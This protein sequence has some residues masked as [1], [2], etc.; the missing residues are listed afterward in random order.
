MP[1]KY[2]IM[3]PFKFLPMECKHEIISM[4][5]LLE[6]GLRL[7]GEYLDFTGGTGYIEGDEGK[8]FPESY[9]WIQ[10]NDF[11]KKYS[12][13][14]SIATI[15]LGPLNFKGCICNINYLGN[16]YRMATYLGVK[17]NQCSEQNVILTQRKY[18][19]IID[20]SKSNGKN[21]SAPHAGNMVRTIKEDISCKANFKFFINNDLL[22][23][24]TD[25]NTS[26]EYAQ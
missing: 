7:N 18:K 21:L 22:F 4:N 8:S 3:G 16:E 12:I 1:I 13:V 6:G 20:V 10:C 9:T 23:D 24:I 5:H 2:D 17:I 14:V 25:E 26:F 15:P 11:Y 19:L